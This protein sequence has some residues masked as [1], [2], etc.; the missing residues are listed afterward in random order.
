MFASA[1]EP[2]HSGDPLLRLVFPLIEL[3]LTLWRAL[4]HDRQICMDGVLCVFV[5]RGGKRLGQA[6]KPPLPSA[7][8]MPGY[9]VDTLTDRRH[10]KSLHTI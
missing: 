5:I 2:N 9:Y 4:V 3:P 7:Y 1:P 6:H 8:Q 10:P